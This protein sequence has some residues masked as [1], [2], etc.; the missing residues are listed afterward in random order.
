MSHIY[1]KDAGGKT[2]S[3][4]RF[5]CKDEFKDL[6]EILEN[7]HDLLPGDQIKPEDPRRWLQLKREMPV[8]DPNTGI[9]RWSI[10][11][12]FTDQ[13][14]FPTFVECKRFEDTRSRREVV[15]QMLEY[16]AN[17][18]HYWSKELLMSYA[19]ET[20][21]EMGKDLD[22]LVSDIQGPGGLSTDEFFTKIESNLRMGQLRLIFFLEQSSMELRS[23]VEF[24]NK[25]MVETEVLLVEARQYLQNGIHIVVPTLFGY[26]EEARLVKRT[27]TVNS[28][29]AR[30]KWDRASFF[31]DANAKLQPNEVRVLENFLDQSI[32]LGSDI[33][34]GTGMQNG[35]FSL[36]FPQLCQRSL[37]SVWSNG[38]FQINLGWLPDEIRKSLHLAVTGLTGLTLPPEEGEQYPSFA[39]YDWI[40]K[41]DAMLRA[42][43]QVIVDDS[44]SG[45]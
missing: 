28:T 8:P 17:G 6:H 33:S 18:H 21:K 38:R 12:M 15:A 29:G 16:A 30:K 3:M 37:Y 9:D 39:I 34:W 1:L 13:D 19:R 24:L 31:A 44:A 25:Q 22:T 35:S 7:N 4:E 20:A 42:I 32:A 27:V 10:D 45:G 43:E 14:A 11:F 2:T 26:T 23:V 40:A 41:A 36:K 5:R